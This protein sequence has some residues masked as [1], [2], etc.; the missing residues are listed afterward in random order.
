VTA[1][2]FTSVPV[3]DI[4]P[5]LGGDGAARRAVARAV[6][7][8]CEEVG[9]LYIAGHGFD[10]DL[11]ERAARA[12]RGFFALPEEAKRRVDMNL[13]PNHRGYVG[14]VQ[15]EPD[16]PIGY[17]RWES[18]KVGFETPADD[19]EFLAGVRFYGP[20]AWPEA[21]ADFRPAMEAYYRAML[22]LAR[23]LFRLFAAALDLDESHFLPWTAKPASIMNVNHYRGTVTAGSP[24]PSGLGAH[25]DYECFA[26]LWQDGSGGLELLNQAGQW[27]AAPPLPGTFVINIGD[28]MAHWTNDRFASTKHRVVH[29]GAADRLSIAF[30]GNC[31]YSTS[32]ACLPTCTDAARPPKYPPT[33]VGE[34]LLASVRRSYAYVDAYKTR[35]AG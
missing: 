9:F 14:A 27:I 10:G 13:F 21:P 3:I 30:F 20:N 7:H 15:G 8:A 28:I 1:Q 29:G 19:P 31:D 33:T 25:S 34:H 24:V 5:F 32:V 16:D 18:F 12:A 17:R 11:I 2:P 4:A 23:T 26:I 22:G 35:G 6:A